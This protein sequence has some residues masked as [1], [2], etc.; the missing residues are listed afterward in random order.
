MNGRVIDNCKVLSVEVEVR[1]GFDIGLVMLKSN[2]EEF[3]ITF[4]NEYMTLERNGVREATFPDLITLINAD[5]G[6]PIL[7]SELK[8]G[9]K[10][11][12]VVVS[13]TNIPL[14]KGLKYSD[15]YKPVEEALGKELIAY[16]N[17]ILLDCD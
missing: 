12:I 3:K 6:M 7:S 11:H 1:G 15:A 5:N 9:M 14:G 4:M 8:N 2:S 10:A 13:R 16:I 17:N